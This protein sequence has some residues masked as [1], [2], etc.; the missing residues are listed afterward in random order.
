[1]LTV[2][3]VLLHS[4][5]QHVQRQVRRCQATARVQRLR[6]QRQQ[7]QQQQQQQ[8]AKLKQKHMLKQQQQQHKHSGS[9]SNKQL[10]KRIVTAAATRI[11][12][13]FTSLQYSATCNQLLETMYTIHR[14][15]H[16][17]LRCTYSFNKCFYSEM[18]SEISQVL[19]YC[20]THC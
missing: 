2:P 18:I 20:C 13:L 11:Q 12:V 17:L 15:I 10:V 16:I 19:T 9:P 3:Y 5:L 8:Q 1:M 6:E 7:L 14:S 4:A